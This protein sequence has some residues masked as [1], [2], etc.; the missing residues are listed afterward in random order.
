MLG[1]ISCEDNQAIR[2]GSS[3]VQIPVKNTSN[4]SIAIKDEGTR[5]SYL[6]ERCLV[7]SSFSRVVGDD[8]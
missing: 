1:I 4:V 8:D 6:A 2:V 5:V 3:A 7:L